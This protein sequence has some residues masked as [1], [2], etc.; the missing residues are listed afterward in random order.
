MA[1]TFTINER[2]Q[3][4]IYNATLHDAETDAVDGEWIDVRGL[5]LW[6]LDISGINGETL[7][8]RG[9]NAEDKPLDSVHERQLGIDITADGIYAN[10]IPMSWMKV[11]ISVGG[12]GSVTARFVGV[13]RKS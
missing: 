4:Q 6:S 3:Q 2:F 13:T 5:D 10:V 8:I 7:Q 11:R 1:P 12:A 9:S